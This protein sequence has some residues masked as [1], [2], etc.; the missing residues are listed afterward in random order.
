MVIISAN[1]FLIDLSSMYFRFS[2]VLREAPGT[3]ATFAA[4]HGLLPP[5]A[6]DGGIP[7]YQC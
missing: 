5:A 3:D 6:E 1:I 7:A 4:H 2:A